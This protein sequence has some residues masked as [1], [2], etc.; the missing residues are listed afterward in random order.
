VSDPNKS[1]LGK[2]LEALLDD[3]TRSEHA[4][5]LLEASYGGA[6]V[7]AEIVDVDRLGVIVERL[8]VQAGSG[9]LEGQAERIAQTVRPAGQQL[10]A[11]EVDTRLHGGVLRTTAEHMV[12]G[13]FYQVGIDAQGAE[14][15]RHHKDEDGRRVRERFTLTREH[16]GRLVDEL[17]EA[18]ED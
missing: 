16:L 1:S 13:R 3:A 14:L 4:P 10:R 15:T 9:D 18:L 17:S 2:A 6:R 12:G 11:V 7:Q 5:G 8:R